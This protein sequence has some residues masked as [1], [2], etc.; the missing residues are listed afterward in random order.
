MGYVSLI[1]GHIDEPVPTK[2]MCKYCETD[3]NDFVIINDTRTYSGIEFS[4]NRQGMLRVRYYED[5]SNEWISE[6]IINIKYC[7]FCGKEC[8]N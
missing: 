3:N 6:D 7:P 5:L 4:I 8:S 2:R 1:D